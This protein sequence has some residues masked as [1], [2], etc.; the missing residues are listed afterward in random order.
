MRAAIDETERR[1]AK[2]VAYNEANGITP[3]TVRKAIKRG[4]ETELRARRTARDAV[5]A[6]EEQFDAIELLAQL[7]KEMLGA[8]ESLEFEKAAA[9]R[10]QGKAL[11]QAIDSGTLPNN[12]ITRSELDQDSSRPAKRKPGT[13]GSKS[14]RAAK[15]T[16]K[17][18]G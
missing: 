18:S 14:G 12:K 8:A 1:R 11:R 7:E 15:R 17:K 10:D 4:M 16:K 6:G 3:Q 9:L 2:Q 5:K 13:P